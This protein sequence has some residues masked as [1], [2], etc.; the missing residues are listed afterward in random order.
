M[1]VIRADLLYDQIKGRKNLSG[2]QLRLIYFVHARR[3]RQ[4]MLEMEIMAVCGI[5][6]HNKK[7]LESLTDQYRNLLFPGVTASSTETF[8]E[9]A[10]R[11]LAIEIKQVYRVS[12]LA[13]AAKREAELKKVI[14]AG[15]AGGAMAAKAAMDEERA[16]S[17]LRRRHRK[18]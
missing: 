13:D 18:R 15:G 16:K 11:M 6:E 1:D 14:G 4:R 2:L 8:E 3:M 17:E 12:K 5:N 10:K 7:V 9:Q